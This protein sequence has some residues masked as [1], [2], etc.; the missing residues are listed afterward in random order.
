MI[1]SSFCDYGDAYVLVKGTTTVQNTAT[2]DAA[3][4]N[5]VK[6]VVFKN[7]APFTGYITKINYAQVDHA[8]DTVIEMPV[9]DLIE[10]SDAY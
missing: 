3:V 10:Y 5:T 9:Y 1:R 2:S 4:S 6:K 8:E 7:C